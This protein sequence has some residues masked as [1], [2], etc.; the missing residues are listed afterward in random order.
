MFGSAYAVDVIHDGLQDYDRLHTSK[1]AAYHD[2]AVRVSQTRT[3]TSTAPGGIHDTE[4]TVRLIRNGDI[5]AEATI[6]DGD[7]LDE[8]IR[9][10]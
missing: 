5:L 10:F 9:D 1:D 3:V 7:V 8:L 6:R 2:Y 4:F